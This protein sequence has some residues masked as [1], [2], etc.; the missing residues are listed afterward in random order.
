MRHVLNEME[1]AAYGTAYQGML[2]VAIDTLMG[3]KRVL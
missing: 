3:R 2:T 1:M